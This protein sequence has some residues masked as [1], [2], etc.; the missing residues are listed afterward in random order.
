MSSYRDLYKCFENTEPHIRRNDVQ[1]AVADITGTPK[2]RPIVATLDTT[3]CRGF[4]LSPKTDHRLTAQFG[5][6]II[7]LARDLNRCWTRFVL[8]KELMHLFDGDAEATDTGEKFESILNEINGPGPSGPSDQTNS[9]F[10]AFWMALGLLC[11]AKIHEELTVARG[12]NHISDYAIATR[13]KIPEVYV[14]HLFRP[15]FK[16]HL[17]ALLE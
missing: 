8:I 3:I 9:E 15:A 14:P 5:G 6:H 17:S 1:D 7:V 12:Q 10:K 4:Y 16:R 13:L 11:P 2:V